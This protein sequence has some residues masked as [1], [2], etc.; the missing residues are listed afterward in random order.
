MGSPTSHCILKCMQARDPRELFNLQDTMRTLR[1]KPK[2]RGNGIILWLFA[3]CITAVLSFALA[4]GTTRLLDGRANLAAAASPPSSFLDHIY[5]FFCP[6]FGGCLQGGQA[7]EEP[8]TERMGTNA[9]AA[10]SAELQNTYR[11][12]NVGTIFTT[13]LLVMCWSSFI[14]HA[15]VYAT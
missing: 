7:G 15:R 12:W 4:A 5:N 10:T 11:S 14:T 2:S 3:F 1:P 13:V 6:W 9:P 8:A